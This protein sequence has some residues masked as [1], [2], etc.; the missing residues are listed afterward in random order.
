M[1]TLV[2]Y[3]LPFSY[4]ALCL[5]LKILH[6][7]CF[8]FLLGITVIPRKIQDNVYAKD[9]GGGRGGGG[10][11]KVHYCIFVYVKMVNCKKKLSSITLLLA[12]KV[13]W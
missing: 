13:Q 3:Y 8:Q 7:Y 10:V 5:P 4:N 1:V 2:T 9:W 6:N 12:N 11:S